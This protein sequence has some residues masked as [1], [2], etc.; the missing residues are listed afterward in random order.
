M[1]KGGEIT[2]TRDLTAFSAGAGEL[3]FPRLYQRKAKAAENFRIRSTV[4]GK[5][6][7]RQSPCESAKGS[8]VVNSGFYCQNFLLF[9]LDSAAAEAFRI[10][11]L[12][13][14]GSEDNPVPGRL[15]YRCGPHIDQKA[16]F[17]SIPVVIA[18]VAEAFYHP[19][20]F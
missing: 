6:Q 9:R 14:V 10:Q 18:A 12:I 13:P 5:S 2:G 15:Q 3:F 1:K 11:K 7:I 4:A 20:Y 17:H 19:R 8:P 16:P